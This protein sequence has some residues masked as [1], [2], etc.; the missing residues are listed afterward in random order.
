MAI[1]FSLTR[2]QQRVKEIGRE[3]AKDFAQRALLH[4]RE[5]SH[6][7]ENFEKL[8][9]AGLYGIALPEDLGGLGIGM[10]GWVAFAEELAQGDASTALAFNMHGVATGGIAQRATIPRKVKER[11]AKLVVD[12][13]RLISASVSEPASSSLLAQSIIPSLRAHPADG[14]YRLH[15]RK[16]FASMFEASDYAYLYAHPEGNPNPAASLALLVPTAQN[17][18][19]V[20]DV[21][22]TLGMRA[23]R[24]NQVTYDGAF[25]PQEFVLYETQSFIDSFIIEEANWAHG[26]YTACYLGIG[27]GI[28]DWVRQYLSNRR[29]KGFAQVMGYAPENS[30]R[31]GEMVTEIEAARLLVYRA[32]WQS[33]TQPPSPETFNWWMRAKLAVGTAVQRV[34]NHA[35]ISCGL[36]ALFRKNGLEI[37]LRDAATAPI[38]PPNSDAAAVMVGLLTMGLN[39][40][41]APSLRLDTLT[42]A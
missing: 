36:H 3:L 5:R 12:D 1:D 24:S 41:E 37:K 18:I 29:A 33:D 30:H 38:Q 13:G 16:A 35:V 34:T 7:A 11:V 40:A 15:G 23:T 42:T 20:E 9:K 4:D 21:W 17:G 6:P 25:V 14:G 39:P 32:A 19:A 8:R 27:L 2:E 10:V 28:V 22:D 26:A 31:L